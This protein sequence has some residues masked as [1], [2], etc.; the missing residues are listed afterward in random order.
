MLRFGNRPF[1]IDGATL[2]AFTRATGIAVEYHED[3]PALED[4]DLVVV[5]SQQAALLAADDAL[6][7]FDVELSSLR[8]ALAR[9]GPLLR[10]PWAATVTGLALTEEAGEVRS[11]S[12]LFSPELAGRVALVRDPVETIGLVASVSGDVPSAVARIGEARDAGHVVVVDTVYDAGFGEPG[13]AVLAVGNAADVAQLQA[14]G[15]KV[16]FV[17][18]SEGGVLWTDDL[19][20][21]R[22]A[23]N[24]VSANEFAVF[25][26]QE[27]VSRRLFASLPFVSPVEGV[28][29]LPAPA[30]RMRDLTP[31]ELASVEAVL[32]P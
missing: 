11:A 23:E 13:G 18:P 6:V 12:A 7:P 2:P 21:P 32:A 15:V 24:V 29:A 22:R 19:V 31:S 28:G 16:S 8:P 30:T 1:Y 26:Y 20:I 3:S 25:V 17:L 10:V 4:R 27:D 5:S 9:P 14:E